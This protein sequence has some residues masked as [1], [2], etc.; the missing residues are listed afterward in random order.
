MS[1][2]TLRR[3]VALGIAALWAASLC[4]PV[5][6]GSSNGWWFLV[7]GWMGLLFGEFAWLANFVLYLVLGLL[8]A[9]RQYPVLLMVLAVFLVIVVF[10]E[11]GR[12]TMVDNEGGIAR[13]IGQRFAGFYLWIAAIGGGAL[14]ALVTAA[15][16]MNARQRRDAAAGAAG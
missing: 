14:M 12:T 3:A 2:V 8:V 13:E 11:L 9:R 6:A 1:A 16:E 10:G 15:V 7:I 4:F 5:W